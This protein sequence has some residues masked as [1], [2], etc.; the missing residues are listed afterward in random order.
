MLTLFMI[1]NDRQTGFYLSKNNL[2]LEIPKLEETMNSRN[3][4]ISM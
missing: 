4:N 3:N 2:S 1:Y